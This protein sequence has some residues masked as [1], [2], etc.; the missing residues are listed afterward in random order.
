MSLTA[1]E[2]GLRAP[3]TPRFGGNLG[4][5]PR[6]QGTKPKQ[7]QKSDLKHKNS[8]RSAKC[9]AAF[10]NLVPRRKKSVG[11]LVKNMVILTKSEDILI[12]SA[13]VL[14][15]SA[16]IL[17]KNEG[18]LVKSEG[19]LT[20]DMVIPVKRLGMLRK[21]AAI[22]VKSEGVLTKSKGTPTLPPIILLIL[23]I[24]SKILEAEKDCL[25][26]PEG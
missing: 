21:S 13:G 20:K 1:L 15:K 25:G 22:L 4:K 3:I 2:W 12:K 24:L 26:Q 19:I 9:V 11:I 16:A 6:L 14:V 8:D 17:A 10:V 7:Q 23:L 5:P 18:L